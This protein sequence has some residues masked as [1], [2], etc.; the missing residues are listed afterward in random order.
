MAVKIIFALVLILALAAGVTHW[1]AARH[2]AQA[3]AAFPPLGSFVEVNGT[4][5]HYIIEGSGPD[6]VLIHGASGNL[7]DFTFDMV[8]RLK[9]RYRVIAFDRPGLG[10]T[11]RLGRDVATITDQADLFVAASRAL[12]LEKPIVMGQS[13]GGS[14]A[15]AWAVHHPDDLSA[16]VLTAAPSNPWTSDLS[17]YYKV[18]SSPWGKV[19]AVPMISAWVPD[20]V[21]EEAIEEVF[22]PQSAPAGYADYIGAALTLRRASIRAN[23]LQRATLLEQITALHPRYGEIAVPTE[24]VHGDADTTVGLPIHSEP[25]SGQIP[26][27][28]LTVLPG[29]GH[30]PHHVA[31]PDVVAAIDRA[32][33]RAGLR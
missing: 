28:V 30:M 22:V 17:T 4:P 8:G 5:V 23:A 13:Y 27:A 25:L 12:G 26:G 9:D 6:L 11:P 14:V 20:S 16:L 31:A 24:L 3:E 18:T 33:A 19:L 21:V 32:A 15:L 7:R 1:K 2:E 29:I 10:Y